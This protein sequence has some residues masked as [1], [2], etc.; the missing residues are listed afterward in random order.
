MIQVY[1]GNGKGKTTAAL[2][3]A[4]R[5]IGAGQNVYIGQFIK[6]KFTSEFNALKKFKNIKIEQ[7]GRGAYIKNPISISDIKC[8]EIGIERAQRV[9][10]SKKFNLIILDEINV[11]LHFKLIKISK[12]LELI[13]NSPKNTEIVLTGRYAPKEIIKKADLVSEIKEI[14]HPYCRRVKARKGIEY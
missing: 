3:L 8:A 2:G 12:V 10:A 1:T 9:I 14:K 4:I 6:G 5:A 11:A 7:C 13:K